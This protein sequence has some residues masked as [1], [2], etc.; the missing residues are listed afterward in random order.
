VKWQ[1]KT[2]QDIFEWEKN[3]HSNVHLKS[4]VTCW[5][6]FITHNFSS[7]LL[8]NKNSLNFLLFYF[9]VT[10]YN[11]VLLLV[12]FGWQLCGL[13][14]VFTHGII[15]QKVSNKHHK[16][17]T[18][19]WC[20]IVYLRSAYHWF[21]S[22]WHIR[23]NLVVFHLIIWKEP[24]KVRISSYHKIAKNWFEKVLR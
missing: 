14:F 17:I 22:F 5:G 9:Q 21:L 4:I 20:T 11:F 16:M 23:I 2:L 8:N 3:T 24:Q 7:S 19:I 1:I 12:F 18:F 10:L 15:Y 6:T 13:T